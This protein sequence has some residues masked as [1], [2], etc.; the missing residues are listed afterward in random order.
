MKVPFNLSEFGMYRHL[1][2]NGQQNS[3]ASLLSVQLNLPTQLLEQHS[4][5]KAIVHLHTQ[6]ILR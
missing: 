2:A 3:L 6:K 4:L 5:F 1:G